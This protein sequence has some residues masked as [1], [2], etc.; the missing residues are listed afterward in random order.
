M[1]GSSCD[2][3]RSS[4]G[5]SYHSTRLRGR[6][7]HKM[8][9]VGAE[10]GGAI[11]WDQLQLEIIEKPSSDSGGKLEKAVSSSARSL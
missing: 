1:E 8:S 9:A 2:A 6:A 11:R 5:L 4:R 3:C 10:G 7:K